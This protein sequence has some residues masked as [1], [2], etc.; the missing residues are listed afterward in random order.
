MFAEP[1]ST[2]S[3]A[4]HSVST[5]GLLVPM[6]QLTE[7]VISTLVF[8]AIGLILFAIAFIIIVKATPFSVRKE[9]EDDQNTAIAIVIASVIIGIAMI[10]SAAIHG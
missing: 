10:V 3:A 5:I 4:P 7:F 9:I 2:L 8:V 6:S 1:L